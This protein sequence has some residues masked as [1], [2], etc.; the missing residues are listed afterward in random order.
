VVDAEA[1]YLADL[2][3]AQAAADAKI[4]EAHA[5]IQDAEAELVK[6]EGN[7]KK[8]RKRAL[9]VNIMDDSDLIDETPTPGAPD[10]CVVDDVFTKLKLSDN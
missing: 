5:L 9:N 8:K 7:A 3:K 2:N 1:A 6:A 10:D 4:A